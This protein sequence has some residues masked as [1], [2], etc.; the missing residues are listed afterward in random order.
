[1][2]LRTSEKSFDVKPEE[3]AKLDCRKTNF[4]KY[5]PADLPKVE[6]L[7][8]RPMPRGWGIAVSGKIGQGT[9]T[10]YDVNTLPKSTADNKP[11]SL[12]LVVAYALPSETSFVSLGWDRR[13]TYKDQDPTARCPTGATKPT[14]EC[15]G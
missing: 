4:S 7:R 6:L 8:A 5:A 1:M 13:K 14:A 15:V 3:A 12:G 10:C 11:W 9:A 2:R